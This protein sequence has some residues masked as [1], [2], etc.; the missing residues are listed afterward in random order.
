M[1]KKFL[2]LLI[3]ALAIISFSFTSCQ[4][5]GVYHPKKKISKI[6]HQSSGG[7][8]S[9]SQMWTWDG[10]QLKKIDHFN[11]GSI[12]WSE[13]FSYDKNR[14]KRV[15]DYE[16]NE[17]TEFKYDGNHLSKSSSYS[18]GS[19]VEELAFHYDGNKMSKI[20]YTSYDYDYKAKSRV[21]PLRYILPEAT[22]E[23]VY[24]SI[25]KK[26]ASQ[27]TTIYTATMKLEWEGKNISKLTIS[28]SDGDVEEYS[29]KYDDKLNPYKGFWSLGAD[30]VGYMQ[31]H[32]NVTEETYRCGAD[33]NICTC[34]YEYDGKFPT[35][36]QIKEQG[37]NYFSIVFYEYED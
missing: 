9:L 21:N 16:Y 3:A 19:V 28:Y 27:K 33:V 37:S 24:T 25:Q 30:E 11:G 10:K 6:Y 35:M 36:E 22:A 4:K 2:P 34:T 15:E 18:D 17:Y 29:Y 13:N 31:S 5:E 8:K 14:L 20:D 7:I 23:R 26:S 12:F 32:N 1:N